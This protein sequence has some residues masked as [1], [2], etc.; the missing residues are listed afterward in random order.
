M[1]KFEARDRPT[2]RRRR[3]VSRRKIGKA[4]T[5]AAAPR[6]VGS[7]EAMALTS[8][9]SP[10]TIVSALTTVVFTREQRI[11]HDHAAELAHS[12]QT[13]R[14]APARFRQ[15]A[16]RYDGNKDGRSIVDTRIMLF[17]NFTCLWEAV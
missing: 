7:R 6:R 10:S 5:A 12:I 2:A 8:A 11:A 14:D 9:A 16:M 1:K 15:S 13:L 17:L 3:V 4:G